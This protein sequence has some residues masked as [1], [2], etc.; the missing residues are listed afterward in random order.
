MVEVMKK[1]D[2][3]AGASSVVWL[4]HVSQTSDVTHQDTYVAI[5]NAYVGYICNGNENLFL[6]WYGW[7][8]L[9]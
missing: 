4:V 7:F 3:R 6:S 1:Q 2:K 8:K 5:I 9:T